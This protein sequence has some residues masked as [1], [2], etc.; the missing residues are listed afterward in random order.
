[1]HYQF[2]FAAVLHGDYLRAFIGGTLVTLAL[3]AVAW[4]GSIV[5]GALLAVVRNSGVR[6]GAAVVAAYVEYHRNVPLV[7]QLLFWYFA[8]PSLFPAWLRDYLASHGSESP[9]AAVALVLCA[10]AYVSED[11]RSGLRAIPRG[12][13]EAGRALGMSYLLTMRT[14]IMPQA[15][16]ISLPP[17]LNQAL[18]LFKNTS[19]AMA[20]GV[21]ELTYEAK[22]VDSNTYRT[23]EAFAVATVIYLAIS[24]AI[25]F[26]GAALGRRFN[27]AEGRR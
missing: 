11:L 26:C 20:V 17:L 3:F 14:V 12:Q 8:A 13:M 6:G 4:L 22:E 16:R 15:L 25:M 27:V 7:V 23:F 9:L 19:L 5:L 10:A 24:F 2:D 18:V 21:A 1:M